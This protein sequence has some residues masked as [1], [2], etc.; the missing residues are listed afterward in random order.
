MLL[1]NLI[2]YLAEKKKPIY[3]ITMAVIKGCVV[4]FTL[5]FYFQV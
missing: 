1:V 5:I 2:V 4:S 3:V